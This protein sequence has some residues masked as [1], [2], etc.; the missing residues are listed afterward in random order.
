VPDWKLIVTVRMRDTD[1]A[2]AGATAVACGAEQRQTWRA[3]SP[4]HIHATQIAIAKIPQL[5]RMQL[6]KS[7][8]GRRAKGEGKVHQCDG[9]GRHAL[10]KDGKE[11][12]PRLRED[13]RQPREVQ[14]IPVAQRGGGGGGFGGGGGGG[15]GGGGFGEDKSGITATLVWSFRRAIPSPRPTARWNCRR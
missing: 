12:Q 10:D 1:Q 4:L 8:Q 3:T 11:V 14:I 2:G 9:R 7:A 6:P 13:A 15:F 5:Y